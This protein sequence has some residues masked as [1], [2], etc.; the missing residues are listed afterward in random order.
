[1]RKFISLALAVVMACAGAS[2]QQF[3]ST[4]EGQTF[5]YKQT[6]VKENKEYTVTS[7]VIK[8][9]TA[10]NGV[11]TGR[12]EE[13]TSD[14]SDL[15]HEQ[16][17]YSGYSFNPADTITKV[18]VMSAEDFKTF[19]LDMIKQGAEASGQFVSDA[20]LAEVA[21]AIK[22][23]GEVSLP[24][25]PNAAGK[26]FSN[27]SI[28]LNMGPQS[29]KILLCKGKYLENEEIEVPAGKFNCVKV[30]YQVRYTGVGADMPDQ[31]VTAW[32]APGIGLV[33]EVEADKKG[34]PRS[35]QVLTA[36]SE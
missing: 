2:A 22:V 29:M 30:S 24:I 35:E 5:T 31:Y 7:K 23:S 8:V 19:M 11:V 33:R 1:M 28:R 14:L 34:N 6:Q 36:I 21:Q 9:D 20:Q 15:L 13:K 17:T 26:T 3:C 10:D 25:R 27:T 12:L 4:K 16:V 18:I 32:Y